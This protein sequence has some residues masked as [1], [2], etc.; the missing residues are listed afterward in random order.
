MVLELILK[1]KA[2]NIDDLIR[3]IGN[4][5]FNDIRHDQEILNGLNVG[6][7]VYIN[8]NYGNYVF[9]DKIDDKKVYYRRYLND[10]LVSMNYLKFKQDFLAL[11]SFVEESEYVGNHDVYMI[12]N[13]LRRKDLPLS[14][15]LYYHQRS[16]LMLVYKEDDKDEKFSFY[17]GNVSHGLEDIGYH[18]EIDFD[19]RRNDPEQGIFKNRDFLYESIMKEIITKN[20]NL[21]REEI[22]GKK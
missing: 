13:G 18:F 2:N 17:S 10:D 12:G 6:Y 21:E 7:E 16:G 15:Y 8:K 22:K 1:A 3:Q 5:S 9:V 14:R 11:R 4:I 19:S 20:S